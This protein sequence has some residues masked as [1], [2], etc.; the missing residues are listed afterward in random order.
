MGLTQQVEQ[1]TTSLAKSKHATCRKKMNH[2]ET[3][4][5]NL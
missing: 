2:G 5:R 1:L 3:E 4:G